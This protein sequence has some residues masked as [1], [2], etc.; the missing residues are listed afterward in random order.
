[1]KLNQCN[2]IRKWLIDEERDL[3]VHA[4]KDLNKIFILMIII[5]I[6]FLL[7]IGTAVFGYKIL[8]EYSNL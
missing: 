1:M 3:C 6:L 7:L 8:K 2:L 5:S 4:T